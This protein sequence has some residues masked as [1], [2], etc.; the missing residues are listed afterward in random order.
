MTEEDKPVSLNDGTAISIPIRNLLAI[1]AAIVLVASQFFLINNRIQILEEAERRAED[2][3]SKN[4]EFRVLWPRGE[5]GFA[6]RDVKQDIRLDHVE[7]DVITIYQRLNSH[8][9][10]TAEHQ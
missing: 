2:D 5:L 9:D 1:G 10:D 8:K 7:A 6:A 3:I 4:T